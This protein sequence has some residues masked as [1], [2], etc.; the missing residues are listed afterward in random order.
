MTRSEYQDAAESTKTLEHQQS[1]RRK[2]ILI[3]EDDP[4]SM[5]LLNDFLKAKGYDTL[6][7]SAGREA[8]NLARNE[9]PDLILMDIRLPDISGLDAARLLKKDDQT[10]DIPIIAVTAFMS[11]GDEANALESGCDAYLGK[12]V[13]IGSLLRLIESFFSSSGPRGGNPQ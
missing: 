13:K 8:I 9:R 7:T 4:R 6:Q 3:V 1:A 10:K 2:R 11:P 12:P 5:M